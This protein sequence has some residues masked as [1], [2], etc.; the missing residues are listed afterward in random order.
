M[1]LEENICHIA[2]SGDWVKLMDDWLGDSSVIQN[3]TSNV[4]TTQKRGFS[5]KRGRK[6]SGMSEVTV[7][8]CSDQSFSWWK[9]GKSTKL[10]FEKAVLPHTVVRNAA[11]QGNIYIRTSCNCCLLVSS[12]DIIFIFL[13][14]SWLKVRKNTYYF[15]AHQ[16]VSENFLVLIM[17]MVLRFLKEVGNWFGELQ[18]KEV[19]LH[20]SLHFR[21]D[22]VYFMLF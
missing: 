11:R 21:F 14:L 13:V 20:H 5:G 19:R 8:D 22:P 7:D 16:A 3:T 18:L 6:H 17:L 4:L 15:V 2:L 9:G 10:V 12:L 1:Q